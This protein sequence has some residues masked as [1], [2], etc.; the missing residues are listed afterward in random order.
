MIPPQVVIGTTYHQDLILH[1]ILLRTYQWFCFCLKGY[2]RRCQI[3]PLVEENGESSIKLSSKRK[4][5]VIYMNLGLWIK[6]Y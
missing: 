4:G 2:V 3:F 5:T 6:D 1:L